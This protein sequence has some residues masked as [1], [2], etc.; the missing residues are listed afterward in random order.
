MKTEKR[1]RQ[2]ATK[3]N[4]GTM[5]FGQPQSTQNQLPLDLYINENEN[6][7][8]G[9]EGEREGRKE[10]LTEAKAGIVLAALPQVREVRSSFCCQFLISRF[11]AGCYKLPILSL[12][13]FL[14]RNL[15]VSPSKIGIKSFDSSAMFNG[16]LFSYSTRF[17]IVFPILRNTMLSLCH[18]NT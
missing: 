5:T 11:D 9:K 12:A 4:A 14:K 18:L 6:G 17:T 2:T 3:W 7:G 10:E 15:G 16:L 8:V 1:N 13:F